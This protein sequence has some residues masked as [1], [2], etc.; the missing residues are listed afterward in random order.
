MYRAV[1]MAHHF[2]SEDE[3]QDASSNQDDG[4]ED[5]TDDVLRRSVGVCASDVCA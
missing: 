2:A 1:C 3:S 4:Q 5:D